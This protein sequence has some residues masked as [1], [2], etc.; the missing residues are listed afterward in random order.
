MTYD[1]PSPPE[2]PFEAPR[3]S[4]GIARETGDALPWTPTDAVVFGWETVKRDPMVILLAFI[5]ALIPQVPSI[6]TQVLTPLLANTAGG[7]VAILVA[8]I[9]TIGGLF[10]TAFFQMTFTR[11]ILGVARGRRAD[12]ADLFK[13]GPFLSFLGAFLVFQIGVTVGMILLIV[14]GVILAL[15][16]QFYAFRIFD[17]GARALDS[18]RESWHLTNGHKGQLF[19]YGLLCIGVMLLGALACCVGVLVAMPV[20]A[21]GGAWI[22][23]RLTGE[24]VVVA[25]REP[26]PAPGAP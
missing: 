15:G 17:T 8:A 24:D 16:C 25:T 13:S 26:P 7:E 18:L 14:P 10:V 4:G 9:V 12:V 11:A 2:N 22:Y 23:L 20:I 6:A 1:E 21:V 19:L 5:T 3:T